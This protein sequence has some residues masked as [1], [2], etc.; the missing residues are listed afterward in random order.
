MAAT[1]DPRGFEALRDPE[2]NRRVHEHLEARGDSPR[3]QIAAALVASRFLRERI[4]LDRAPEQ[5][6]RDCGTSQPV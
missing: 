4:G 6:L 2:M 1:A 5:I 3:D